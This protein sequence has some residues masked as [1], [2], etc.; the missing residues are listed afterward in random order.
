MASKKQLSIVKSEYNRANWSKRHKLRP[1]CMYK[2]GIAMNWRWFELIDL[3]RNH[4]Y[5]DLIKSNLN[6]V[7][8]T[9]SGSC[10]N[11]YW[12]DWAP[13]SAEQHVLRQFSSYSC[14]L[15]LHLI[16]HTV[17]AFPFLSFWTPVRAPLRVASR[18]AYP[19]SLVPSLS[20]EASTL[21]SPSPVPL[22]SSSSL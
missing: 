16:L 22:I 18:A 4:S 13:W 14:T 15:S 8:F 9:T 21:W 19:W 11:S 10:S 20:I 12:A 7:E 1:N 17:H 3:V 5:T 6:G 2:E